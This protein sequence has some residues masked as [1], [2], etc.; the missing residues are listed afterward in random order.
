[1]SRAAE[2]ATTQ[3]LLPLGEE[4]PDLACVFVS[5][6]EGDDAEAALRHAADLLDARTVLGCTGHG[7]IGSAR[8]VE[9][10]PAVSVWTATLPGSRTR[11]FHLEVL[12]TDQS[13]SVV[14]MPPTDQ[15]GVGLLLADAWT[16]PVDGFVTRSNATLSGLPLVG[17]LASGTSG[18]G[19][20]RLLLD[21]RVTDRGAVG[22]LVSG[23]LTRTVVSQGCRPIGPVMTVTASDGNVLLGLAGRPALERLRAVIAELPE[24]DQ[25]LAVNGLQVGIAMDEYADEHGYG[26]FLVRGVLG[27]D[28]DRGAVAVGDVVDVGRTV[29]FQLRDAGAADA[30]LALMLRRFREDG[31]LAPEGALLVSC[32]GRG[33]ALFD[34]AAHDVV[35]VREGLGTRRVAGFFAAGEI[36][37]VGGRNHVHGLS[38]SMLVVGERT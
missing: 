23:D 37:P 4:R 9:Q 2:L 15:A 21:G 20:T 18:A 29:Q 35:A 17:G 6:V 8:G 25:V 14:G 28:E 34:D 13:L 32:N 3:A 19:S 22:V 33:R 1:M 38:A 12:R 10:L 27:V 26:D 16:F 31:G 5:G 30:D 24:E 36:G 11:S 7:V